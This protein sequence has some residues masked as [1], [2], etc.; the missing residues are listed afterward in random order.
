ML[1][2]VD[3]YN[4]NIIRNTIFENCDLA[5]RM[6]SGKARVSDIKNNKI[7]IY[8]EIYG[9]KNEFHKTT[10]Y[11]KETKNDDWKDKD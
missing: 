7:L 4:D 11:Q 5:I 6:G 3:E 8:E 10:K 1:S 9:K 2:S